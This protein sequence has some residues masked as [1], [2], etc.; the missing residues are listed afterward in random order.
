[1][2]TRWEGRK[3]VQMYKF[4]WPSGPEGSPTPDYIAYVL[5]FSVLSSFV[6]SATEIQSFWFSIK[7]FSWSTFA[8]GPEKTSPRA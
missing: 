2:P 3:P 6:N 8:G 7:I 5:S 1:M 4:P